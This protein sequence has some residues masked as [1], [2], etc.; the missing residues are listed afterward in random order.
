[1]MVSGIFSGVEGEAYGGTYVFFA[2]DVDAV[3]MGF[4]DVLADG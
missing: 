3:A 2:A 1:M 4:D